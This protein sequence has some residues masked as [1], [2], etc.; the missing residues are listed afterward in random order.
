MTKEEIAL[1]ARP[2]MA[3]LVPERK[4]EMGVTAHTG[5]LHRGE[6]GASLLPTPSLQQALSKSELRE[7]GAASSD[8]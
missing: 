6:T 7:E 5:A 4:G 1:L 3:R 8:H 2:R